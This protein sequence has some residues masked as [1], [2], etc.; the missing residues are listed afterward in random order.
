MNN[1]IVLKI[2]VAVLFLVMFFSIGQA[3][4]FTWLSSF[5]ERAEQ[6]PGLQIKFWIWS[7]VACFSLAINVFLIFSFF[8]NRT[9]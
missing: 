9:E 6:L 7:G 2:T 5:P 3:L 1:K 8:K 4:T